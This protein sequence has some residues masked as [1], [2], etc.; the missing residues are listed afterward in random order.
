MKTGRIKS[1]TDPNIHYGSEPAPNDYYH[2]GDT[3]NCI[4]IQFT[5]NIKIST[6]KKAFKT[7]NSFKIQY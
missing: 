4:K 2:N 5:V 1:I 3:T 6:T 7:I